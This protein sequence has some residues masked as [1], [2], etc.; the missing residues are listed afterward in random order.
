MLSCVGMVLFLGSCQ[1]NRQ[2]VNLYVKTPFEFLPSAGL[3]IENEQL[4]QKE[5]EKN[6]YAN[7]KNNKWS[8]SGFL[9]L[10]I[11]CGCIVSAKI[12]RRGD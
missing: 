4:F 6:E 5:K 12:L 11:L 7:G 10:A 9:V 3:E 1:E 2:R 8:P